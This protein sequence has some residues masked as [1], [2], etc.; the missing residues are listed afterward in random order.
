[1][2]S[3]KVSRFQ[4]DASRREN[5]TNYLADACAWADWKRSGRSRSPYPIGSLRL[6]NQEGA[7][8]RKYGHIFFKILRE[9]PIRMV[10]SAAVRMPRLFETGMGIFLATFV[11]GNILLEQ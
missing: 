3:Q 5:R 10:E 9:Q 4:F 2:A 8:T 11:M 6:R 1:M 7:G